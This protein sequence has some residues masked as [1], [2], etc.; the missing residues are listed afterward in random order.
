[1]PQIVVTAS[2]SERRSGR[3]M[4]RERVS[5]SDLESELFIAH[6]VERIEWALCDADTV[7]SRE[8]ALN[9]REDPRRT[10]LLRA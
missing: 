6:L 3:E 2:T 1:M 5:L 9:A 10:R 8:Q 7:E 4:M